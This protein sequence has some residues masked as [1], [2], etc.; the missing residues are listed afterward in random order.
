MPNRV[1]WLGSDLLRGL[2]TGRLVGDAIESEALGA[3]LRVTLAGDRPDT[4]SRVEA[5]LEPVLPTPEEY[6]RRR[7]R[8][9]EVRAARFR[10]SHET[11]E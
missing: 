1:L 5:A 2:D 8:F 9:H 10:A 11:G 3:S 6:Q 4:L 7:D